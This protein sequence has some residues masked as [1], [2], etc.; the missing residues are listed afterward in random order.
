[1]NI[2][3]HTALDM[4]FMLEKFPN[5]FRGEGLLEG[6]LHLEVDSTV[7]PVKLPPRMPPITLREKY[8]AELKRLEDLSIITK[9]NEPSD[10]ISS[11]V[12]VT[13]PNGKIRL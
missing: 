5:V 10:W 8:K 11:A 4:K 1:M 9:V 13:K 2:E 6:D 7:P 12:V 3:S